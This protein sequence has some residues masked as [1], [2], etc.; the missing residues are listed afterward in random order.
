MQTYLPEPVSE[1]VLRERIREV[2]QETG[3]EVMN[4]FGKIMIVLVP[5]FRGKADNALIK[6]LAGEFLN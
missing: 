1:D 6:D 3:A 5:E 2:I 4:D